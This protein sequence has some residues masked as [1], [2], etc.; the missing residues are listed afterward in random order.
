MGWERMIVSGPHY[1][2][3]YESGVSI[4]DDYNFVLFWNLGN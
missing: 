1:F 4:L 2:I 3:K